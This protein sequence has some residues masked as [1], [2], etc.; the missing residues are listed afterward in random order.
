MTSKY[1]TTLKWQ[2]YVVIFFWEYTC[3]EGPQDLAGWQLIGLCFRVE[4]KTFCCLN[5][6]WL[7]CN[8][9]NLQKQS[10]KPSGSL[11]CH[12]DFLYTFLFISVC[13][14]LFC[15]QNW[16]MQSVRLLM[17]MEILCVSHGKS[18]YTKGFQCE[19]VPRVIVHLLNV[20]LPADQPRLKRIATWWR[21]Y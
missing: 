19:W 12:L 8:S 20:C 10:S 1:P 3:L 5:L 17:V 9:P 14:L 4:L 6:F 11:I 13:I 2:M 16:H 21:K 15:L 7:H 18:A